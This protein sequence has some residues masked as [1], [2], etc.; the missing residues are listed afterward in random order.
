MLLDIV[1]IGG[2]V[3]WLPMRA[4]GVTLVI[5]DVMLSGA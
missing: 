3:D 1:E 5:R 4:A 2:D